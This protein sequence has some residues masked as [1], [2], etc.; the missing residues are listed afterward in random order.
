MRELNECTQEVFRRSEKRI[1]ERRRKRGRVLALCIPV[2]LIIPVL[3]AMIFPG[4]MPVLETEGF[5]Q[6]DGE[7]NGNAPGLP[8]CPYTA[9]EIQNSGLSPGE[10]YET[11]TDQPV[12]AEMCQAIHSLFAEAAGNDQ[13]S[14]GNLPPSEIFPAAE[15]VNC[16]Q[17]GS[18]S[19]SKVYTITFTA[20]EGSQT[21][22]ILSENTL[23]DVN[24]NKTISLSSVQLAGLMAVLGISK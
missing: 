4:V 23:M 15:D 22:Y 10:H 13:D 2:C 11:V 5:A 19:R 6:A 9:V 24:G 17:T 16:D 21:V 20:E 18:T 3:S 1:K 14:D 8:A 7:M 12:V